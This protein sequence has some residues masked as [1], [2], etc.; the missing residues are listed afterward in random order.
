MKQ[1]MRL[2]RRGLLPLVCV[3]AISLATQAFAQ[4]GSSLSGTVEDTSGAVIPNATVTLTNLATQVQ[5]T[6]TTGG[7]GFYRFSDLAGGHYSVTVAANGFQSQTFSDVGLSAELA[8]GLDVKLPVGSSSQTV[9]VNADEVPVLNTTDAGIS[10][11]ISAEAVTRL[12]IFGRDP[13]EL[14]RTGVGITGDGARAGNGGAIT[15]PNNVSQNQSNY[16]IFQTENQIQISASGQRV[17]SNTY[18]IDGVTVDSLLHGGAAVITPNP[19]SVSQITILAANYDASLGRSVGAHVQTVTNAGGNTVHGSMFFQY[20]E[21]GLNA[22]QSYGGPS[23]T[24][25][26]FAPPTRNDLQQREWA[27][28]LGGP[29]IKDKLFWFGSYEAA[30][31]TLQSFSLQYVPT[32][33][34][35]SGLAAAQPNGLV[36]KTIT[37]PGGQ[38]IVHA[39]VP[40]SCT[41]IQTLCTPVGTGFDIGSFAGVP[42][43]YLPNVNVQ[44]TP[45]S[46]NLFTGGGQ[47]GIPDLEYA[48]IQTP[49]N[50]RGTQFNGR[51]DWYLTP[52]DQIYGGF[53]T[54]KLDQTSLDAASGAAP[55]TA[56][57]FRPFNSSA[58]A[59][60]IHTFSPTLIN[61]LRANYTRFSDNQIKDTAGQVNWGVPGMYVQ[62]YGFQI[63]LSIRAAPTTPYIAAENTYELRD[64]VTK[65]FGSHSVRM[66]FVGRKEQDNDDES[67]LA[68]PNYA[69]QGIWDAANDA[70][71]YEGIA[72]N[73]NTGGVGNAQR[74]FRRSYFAGFVQDDWKAKPNLTVNIGLRYE[75]FGA[76]TNKGFQIN[77]LQ[78]GAPGSEMVN[79]KLVLTN[80]LYPSTPD[81]F[82]PKIGFAWQPLRDNGKLVVHGGFGVSF[83]NLDE[84]PISPAYE[85]GP[86]YFNYGLC[87]AGLQATDP[88]AEG[89]GIVFNYGSSD[90]PF[91]YPANPNLATGVN[92]VT[93]T[94]NQY[95]GGGTPFTPQ[96]ETYGVLKIKQP[97]LYNY[98]LD[99]Q[100]ELPYQMALTIGYQGASGFHF[101]RLV[102][103]DFIYPTASGT[104]PPTCT[105]GVNQTPFYAAYVPTSDVHTSYN[106]LNVHLEKRLQHG[107]NFSGVYTWSKSL[108]NASEE[109]PGFLSNQTDPAFP[110]TEYGPSDFDARHRVT[111]LGVWSIPSP[112]GNGWK[113]QVLGNWQAN[114]IYTWHTGFPWTPV[115][116]VPSVVFVNG[117]QT[118]APTRPT[119][120]GIGSGAPAGT[121]ASNDCSNSAYIHGSNFPLGGANYF[122]YGTPGPPG[123]GRNSFNGPCYQDT[124]VS[125]AKQ[126]TFAPWGHQTL[127]RF[128]ANI[129]NIFNSTNLQPIS[130]GSAESTI[131]YDTTPGSHVSNPQFGISPGADSGR[132]IEF[133]GRIQF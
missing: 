119:G 13:Y 121:N 58:T 117:A 42:G 86:N 15:L 37:G 75:Y 72:A 51:V 90:S 8:R 122:V 79:S 83:D 29:I 123:I 28:S 59:V 64:M 81:A 61:E 106:A 50:Y 85:N 124:D 98:S 62:N 125:V 11:T 21:P 60:Y 45:A 111:L 88:N 48:Q 73:P 17:T 82:A 109:G 78:L 49:S 6:T 126:I 36:A 104:C 100:R 54:Q 24:P 118:I 68:R 80:H 1:L 57:P 32:P 65:I 108:D 47:D 133:F 30:K 27:A 19:E 131:S 10:S 34:F 76:L 103:Q 113:K 7:S 14:L 94:P 26:V 129:Y 128:Q 67:G 115:I 132:V 39:V 107:F 63:D 114:A 52:K 40:G 3:A 93:G 110:Q 92:P 97:T 91:S 33:Q 89:T 71:L 20:D 74:Y 116:G 120:Y 41:Q 84:A 9:T 102:N 16:G 56:L 43:Q 25:G 31:S 105:P 5:K 96:V 69:F 101:L 127:V 44:G 38:A 66:G 70:P 2:F 95:N 112:A 18:S 12:P 46:P 77:N 53:Y 130:F 22:Y 55:D 4:F 23:G 99:V 35:Y 87:C